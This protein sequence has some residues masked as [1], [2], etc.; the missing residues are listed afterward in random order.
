MR[1]RPFV[2]FEPFLV[3]V[4]LATRLSVVLWLSDTVP[5]SDFALYHVAGT[6]IAL[7]PGFLFDRSVVRTF[8][9]LNWWPP[10]YPLFLGLVYTLQGPDHRAAI[11]VQVLLGTLVCWIVYRIGA[12]AAGERAGRVAGLLVALNPS[13]VFLTNQLASENLFVFWLAL[14]LFLTGR[15]TREARSYVWPGVVLA[16]GA[17][18][19]A[20]GLVVPIVAASWMRARMPGRREWLLGVAWL[21]GGAA[22]TLAPWALRNAAVAGHPALVCF[23]GGLNFYFGHNETKIGY[24]EPSKTPLASQREL[25]GMDREGYRLGFQHIAEHPLGTLVESARKIVDLYAFPDYALHANSGILVPDFHARPELREE[26]EALLAKQRVRDRWLHGL[27]MHLARAHSFLL[28]LGALAAAVLFRR[29]LP[30]ELRLSVWLVLAWTAAH[31]VFWA[32]PR[33][34]FPVEIP[35]ALLAGYTAARLWGRSARKHRGVRA[36]DDPNG[37]EEGL[38]RPG[39]TVRVL[40]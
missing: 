18:T 23:G 29:R 11:F 26:A 22:V 17:L 28:L 3:G 36:H 19:R 39:T 6:Q 27:F 31:V 9:P 32:Q 35:L 12:R 10:G 40:G 2:R 33:F 24:R 8:L 21:L 14:G 34:R 30:D 37:G 38:S 15:K 25:A 1:L 7:D 20:A 4:A 16:L 13:Y 5:Y